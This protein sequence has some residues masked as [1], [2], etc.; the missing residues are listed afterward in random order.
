MSVNIKSKALQ[1]LSALRTRGG[2]RSSSSGISLR[3]YESW[4]MRAALLTM[5]ILFCAYI[6]SMMIAIQ[7]INSVANISYDPEIG[8]ALDAQLKTIKELY[9]I[10]QQQYLDKI[11]QGFGQRRIESPKQLR[12]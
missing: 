10:K 2:L 1:R 6:A 11:T 7:S 3:W 12:D 5:F 9:A 4:I 8:D